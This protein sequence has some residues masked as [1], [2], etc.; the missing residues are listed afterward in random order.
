MRTFCAKIVRKWEKKLSEN[1]FLGIKENSFCPKFRRKFLYENGP[2][3]D[4]RFRGGQNIKMT[5]LKLQKLGTQ[6]VKST[7]RTSKAN[8]RGPHVGSES[9][10]PHSRES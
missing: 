5:P 7:P 1:A 9:S 4:F 8:P 6:G 2:K 10:E 3:M